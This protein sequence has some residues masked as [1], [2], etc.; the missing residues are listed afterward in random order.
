MNAV[1]KVFC[2]GRHVG[3][4]GDETRRATR[5]VEGFLFKGCMVGSMCLPRRALRQIAKRFAGLKGADRH[6]G[7]NVIIIYERGIC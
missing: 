2:R 4:Y 6:Y 1:A 3:G 7:G 5:K